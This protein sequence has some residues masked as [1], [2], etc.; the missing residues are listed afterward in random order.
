M[1]LHYSWRPH[2]LREEVHFFRGLDELNKWLAD[3]GDGRVPHGM[4]FVMQQTYSGGPEAIRLAIRI[5][6]EEFHAKAG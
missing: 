3:E 4:G 5:I 6:K 1:N 2:T